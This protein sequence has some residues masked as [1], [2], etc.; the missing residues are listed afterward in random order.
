MDSIRDILFA[1]SNT[2]ASFLDQLEGDSPILQSIGKWMYTINSFRPLAQMELHL[3][4]SALFPIIIGAHASL[5]RPPSAGPPEKDEVNET[6]DLDAVADEPINA[7]LTPSDAIL[8]PVTAG[9]TLG[10]LYY[11]IVYLKRADLVNLIMNGYLSSKSQDLRTTRPL[12]TR[13][14]LGIFGV[15][16]LAA[17]TMNILTTFVFPSVWS[18]SKG[19]YYVEPL[20]R[21]QVSGSVNK[22]RT[23]SVRKNAE[24]KTNP[25]PGLMSNIKFP[26][27]VTKKL[28]TLRALL[29]GH[30]I[31][32]AYV[33][34]VFKTKNNIRL[35]TVVGFT[36]GLATV[37]AYNLLPGRSWW[38]T[39]ILGFNFSYGAI[40]ILSPTTFWTGTLVLAG[41]FVYDIVMVFYSPMMIT[42]AKNLSAPVMLMIPGPGRGSMLGLGDIVLPGIFMALALRFDLYL[43]YLRKQKSLSLDKSSKNDIIKAPYVDAT[44]GWGERYWT[45]RNTETTVADGARFSKVY[46]KA[47]IVGYIIA[48]LVTMAIMFKYQHGQPALLYLVPGVLGA[49]W[50]T[51]VVRGETKLMW[52]YTEDGEWGFEDDGKK[53]SAD[54][55]SAEDSV[56]GTLKAIR[57]FQ[58]GNGANGLLANDTAIEDT[59][60]ESDTESIDLG[61][62]HK[63]D[64]EEKKAEDENAHHV[65]LFSLSK[66]QLKKRK[67]ALKL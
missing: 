36:I 2:M 31:F 44:G 46:F 39:N 56:R 11:A 34:G 17:D 26:N 14:V 51:A 10:G 32:R 52:E 23:L 60:A 16:R 58:A 9:L 25:F 37:A 49:V 47:S 8:F 19:T 15:G 33:H 64:T 57:G 28:W 45:R 48:M 40:Q 43:H 29:T 42:V 65:F 4:L 6:D 38:L 18:S 22:S 50:G 20:L 67:D 7:G 61:K 54:K 12:L 55:S 13:I 30:W 35:S 5:K 3:I 27:Y 24:G 63:S 41:L 66:P 62:P 53:K 59:D 1:I 21:E